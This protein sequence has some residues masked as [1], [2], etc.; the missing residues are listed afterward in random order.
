MN[1]EQ[2]EQLR[3]KFIHNHDHLTLA[4]MR[5]RLTLSNIRRDLNKL[6]K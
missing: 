1:I 3:R 4:A 2:I 5:F 6:N